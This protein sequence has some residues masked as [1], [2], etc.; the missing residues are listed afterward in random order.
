MLRVFIPRAAYSAV[1]SEMSPAVEIERW[2]ALKTPCPDRMMEPS[3]TAADSDV[4]LDD[5]D[6]ALWLTVLRDKIQLLQQGLRSK[7]RSLSFHSSSSGSS[8][9]GDTTGPTAA[10]PVQARKLRRSVSVHDKQNHAVHK[11]N[12]SS[13][14][15]DSTDSD[16]D[17]DGGFASGQTF[18]R[19]GSL[20]SKQTGRGRTAPSSRSPSPSL[21]PSPPA[22]LR[23][24]GK[25]VWSKSIRLQN[26]FQQAAN[27]EKRRRHRSRSK[28]PA[29]SVGAPPM[30]PEAAV[31]TGAEDR[32][33]TT[34]S[35]ATSHVTAVRVALAKKLG[36]SNPHQQVHQKSPERQGSRPEPPSPTVTRAAAPDPPGASS[37]RTSPV[38]NRHMSTFQP[39]G[40]RP[41]P[42]E[43]THQWPPAATTSPRSSSSTSIV[44]QEDNNSQR[45][46]CLSSDH[47]LEQHFQQYAVQ[48]PR[49]RRAVSLHGTQDLSSAG[50]TCSLLRVRQSQRRSPSHA[51]SQPSL[52]V[53][54]DPA[55]DDDCVFSDGDPPDRVGDASE[56]QVRSVDVGA[57]RRL[58]RRTEARQQ[59]RRASSYHQPAPSVECLYSTLVLPKHIRPST[60]S[61]FTVEFEK[62]AKKKSLGFSIVGGKDS[63]KGNLGIFVKTIFAGGQAAEQ[64]Q[65][66][67]GDEIF[68]V[69]GR[70]VEGLSH[71][72]VVALFRS[73]KGAVFIQIGRKK[74]P[75]NRDNALYATIGAAPQIM[76]FPTV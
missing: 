68:S 74:P 33:R 2:S 32:V 67:E 72:E 40:E 21:S 13:S 10:V 23:T 66:R 8:K 20:R 69:N 55:G 14:S 58:T 11:W 5:S 48:H 4:E 41:W 71:A 9:S 50:L 64:G 39:V 25:N 6:R 62:G 56:P 73:S 47:E 63:P 35:T 16:D 51:I 18:T 19:V 76:P 61:L 30:S 29:P 37:G 17:C 59:L 46:E 75:K 34:L 22:K 27:W 57:L 42:Q 54:S 44:V 7:R 31:G 38:P 1:A 70:Q 65:L 12:L 24:A 45:S 60:H 53:E 52:I 49:T 15:H 28:A 43:A 26:V 3:P 36:F